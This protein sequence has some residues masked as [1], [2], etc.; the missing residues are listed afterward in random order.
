MPELVLVSASVG[1]RLL[2]LVVLPACLRRQTRVS[3]LGAPK[4]LLLMLNVPL[5]LCVAITVCASSGP[6]AVLPAS[7]ALPLPLLSDGF[8]LRCVL[9]VEA[10]D[11]DWLF[12]LVLVFVLFPFG[13]AVFDRPFGSTTPE[14][15]S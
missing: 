6:P 11:F 12:V 4:V 10:L 7:L 8:V 13:L 5:L 3:L 15:W 1:V 2:L 9:P 14:K